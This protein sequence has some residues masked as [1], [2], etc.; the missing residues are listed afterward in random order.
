M[1]GP[2]TGSVECFYIPDKAGERAIRAANI[3]KDPGA[4]FYHAWAEFYTDNCRDSLMDSFQLESR[5]LAVHSAFDPATRLCTSE[6]GAMPS[7]AEEIDELWDLEDLTE[8][9]VVTDGVT[10]PSDAAAREELLKSL[11]RQDTME[12]MDEEFQFGSKDGAS[13]RT[14]YSAKSG[15]QSTVRSTNTERFAKEHK[16]RALDNARMA[17]ELADLHAREAALLAREQEMIERMRVLEQCATAPTAAVASVN[18]SP[19]DSGSSPPGAPPAHQNHDKQNED[20]MDASGDDRGG[21]QG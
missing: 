13:R 4:F 10:L 2:E 18:G 5:Q 15:G 11:D 7:F 14:N 21:E 20:M 16:Q 17:R 1:R 12:D 8:S 6:F 19:P 9:E 3:A